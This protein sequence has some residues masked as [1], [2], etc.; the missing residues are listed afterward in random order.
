MNTMFD[1]GEQIRQNQLS[2]IKEWLEDMLVTDIFSKH[3]ISI[4]KFSENFAKGIIAH[5]V[6]VIQSKKEMHDCPIMNKF[7]NLMLKKDIKSKEILIIC[8]TLRTTVITHLLE[9][10]P[11]LIQDIASIKNVL[12]IFDTNLSGVLANFDKANIE[13]SVDKHTELHLKKY[14]SRLQT[15]LDAQDNLIFK[16]HDNELYIANKALYLT[17]GAKDMTTF[18]KKYTSPLS[19]IKYV[20]FHNSLF[21]N[22][23]HAEWID[24]IVEQHHGQCKVQVFDHVQNQ[25]SLMKIK[26]TKM[27]ELNDFIFTLEDI[28]EQQN[29]MNQLQSLVYKDSLTDMNNL[30]GFE[31][32]LES[33]LANSQ[34]DNLKI[35][36]LELKGLSL[37][38]G[39][40]PKETS[41]KVIVD[42]AKSIKK[43][44]PTE[45]SRVDN[46]R[47]AILS[48]ELSLE[49]AHQLIEELEKAI[50]LSKNT[51]ALKINGA[52]IL[53][54][55]KDTTDSIIERGELLLHHT[56][57]TPDTVII[58]DYIMN[59][60]EQERL[61]QQELFLSVMKEYKENKKTIPITNYY[62]EIPLKSSAK[63]LF[64]TNNEMQ[65][66]VRKIS[67]IA[68][69][70]G[71]SVYIEMGKG[72]NFKANVKNINIDKDTLTLEH[73]KPIKTSPLN[74]E[75]LHV[76]LKH[77][78]EVL[79]KSDKIQ[80][81]EELDTVSIRTFVVF[82]NHLYNIKENSELKMY[83]N[84]TGKEEEF[85]GSVNKIIPV[86]DKFKII[87]HL[88]KTP[89]I[90][91]SLV[92][93][94]S[95][96][97]MEIIKELQDKAACISKT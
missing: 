66:S 49:N 67:A 8:V 37:Y 86:A 46:G 26:I 18:K 59:K 42:V 54:H 84:F 87:I 53:L 23:N 30:K 71:D 81:P 47:F 13:M 29:K 34:N 57:N 68:L 17:T 75:T 94:I 40:N 16:L 50:S 2:I 74:R 19:F 79:L 45:A 38:S 7:V 52:I 51:D 83:V 63:I 72:E 90:E 6:D 78:I 31:Q 35:L 10:S 55:E 82:I 48:N 9:N 25:T 21:K 96:R 15:I 39:Q 64:I 60:Q 76:K 97:Q 28:T 44:Y 77:P 58:D 20:D 89:S 3:K 1:I 62:L 88:Q 93:F 11:H 36:I 73:F 80:I 14:L 27:G 92:S 70:N 4:E 95:N 5:T 61:K 65:V 41:E 69:N 22:G 56:K 12:K 91:Q 24:E 85:I 32:L 33:K 43:Y